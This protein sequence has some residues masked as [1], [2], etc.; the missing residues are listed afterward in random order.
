MKL[1]TTI[2]AAIALT[3]PTADPRPVPNAVSHEA[4]YQAYWLVGA[5][6]QAYPTLLITH[7]PLENLAG[8]K[9][10]SDLALDNMAMT[11]R[12]YKKDSLWDEPFRLV[13]EVGAVD[14]KAKTVVL[15]GANYVYEPGSLED[16]V[17]LMEKPDGTI[18]ISRRV[19][20]L[21]GAKRTAQ[22]FRL[23]LQEQMK[24]EKK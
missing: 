6:G 17:R 13:Q 2:A 22:A 24:S 23:L 8:H 15:D 3:A 1:L 16:V 4:P 19:D 21:G 11:F 18:P 7:E 20:P 10:S 9:K 12:T 5:D 14:A